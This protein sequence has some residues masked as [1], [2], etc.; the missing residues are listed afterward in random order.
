MNAVGCWCFFVD[1][2]ERFGNRIV[3]SEQATLGPLLPWKYR[4]FYARRYARSATTPRTACSRRRFSDIVEIARCTCLDGLVWQEVWPVVCC[5]RRSQ[6]ASTH[7]NP[8]PFLAML[9]NRQL[10]QLVVLSLI[11]RIVGQWTNFVRYYFGVW[12]LVQQGAAQNWWN[13]DW[14]RVVRQMHQIYMSIVQG[15]RRSR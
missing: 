2:A 13:I 15:W 4:V 10:S 11:L 9:Y 6:D 14:A 3:L 12:S 8:T 5:L 1:R 7:V